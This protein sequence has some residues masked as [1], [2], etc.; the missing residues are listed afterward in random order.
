MLIEAIPLNS[1]TG[2]GLMSNGLDALLLEEMFELVSACSHLQV[3]DSMFC[4]LAQRIHRIFEFKRISILLCGENREILKTVVIEN[5]IWRE[6][7]PE[8][9]Q[10]SEMDL[11]LQALIS[12]EVS[13][14]SVRISVPM[15]SGGR[16]I[17][18]LCIA[19]SCQRCSSPDLRLLQFLAVIL[20]GSFERVTRESMITSLRSH[21]SSADGTP[22][23]SM[24]KSH[25]V[26][27]HMSYLAQHDSLTDLPNRWLLYEHLARAMALSIR[28]QRR[29]AVLFLDLDRFKKINDS[30][31]HSIGDQVLCQVSERLAGCV[32]ASDTV[33]RIGGDEFV[34]VL[35]ELENERDATICAEKIAAAV[36]A[37]LRIDDKDIH[38]TLSIGIAIYPGDGDDADALIRSADTAM[39]RAKSEGRDK[40]SFFRDELNVVAREQ[41]IRV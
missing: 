3:H 22:E 13:S 23:A 36:A 21:P 11:I 25:A 40:C 33:G 32:R 7:Q 26:S 1:Q 28:Y 5:R 16:M 10:L 9:I 38:I 19:T 15:L 2:G 4:L 37:P 8:Q 41:E 30:M 20:A 6:V 34:V 24:S 17:G 14:G 27:L 39:Y 31:G 18:L 29:L 12:G 35:A